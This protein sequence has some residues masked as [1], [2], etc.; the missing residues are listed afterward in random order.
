M[1]SNTQTTRMK[2]VKILEKN[3]INGTKLQ[4]TMDKATG[5]LCNI[6]IPIK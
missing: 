1:A 2:I 3:I 6:N 4:V 5:F